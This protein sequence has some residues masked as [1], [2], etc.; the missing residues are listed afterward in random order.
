VPGV[1]WQDADAAAPF[2]MDWALAVVITWPPPKAPSPWPVAV[3]YAEP[4]DAELCAR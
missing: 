1:P 4:A 3:P 2:A